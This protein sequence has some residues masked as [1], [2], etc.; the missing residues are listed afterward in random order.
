LTARA[1]PFGR[2]PRGIY[3]LVGIIAAAAILATFASVVPW[4]V[5]NVTAVIP[6]GSE[7]SS[8]YFT[9]GPGGYIHNCDT[10]ITANTTICVS[11]SY[12][13]NAGSGTEKITTLY[14]SILGTAV[15]TAI[16]A[17]AAGFTIS[18]GL[19][20]RVRARRART[21]VIVF[22]CLALCTSI[23]STALL[24][25]FQGEAFQGFSGGCPGFN[26]TSSPCSSFIGHASCIGE[27]GSVC[28]ESNLTWYPQEGWYFL[29][30]SGVLLVGMLVA[31]HFQPLGYPCPFC[32][33]PNRFPARY[34]DTCGRALPAE[35]E[36][37]S[38]GYRL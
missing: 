27:N 33:T 19:Q 18:A 11:F 37:V 25:A 26:N 3:V 20:G 28:T 30:G 7:S 1:L 21:M 2:T 4:Y 16:L 6:G 22:V 12:D 10:Y 14:A 13:Y 29:I 31:L 5:N 9:P 17:C 35:Q 36:K 38:T 15:A 24:P 8:Q 23:A 34:C 32:G